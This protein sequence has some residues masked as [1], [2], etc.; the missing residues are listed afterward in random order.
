MADGR[1]ACAEWDLNGQQLPRAIVMNRIQYLHLRRLTIL[2]GLAGALLACA[3]A[4]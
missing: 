1:R 3:T 4:P 2:A